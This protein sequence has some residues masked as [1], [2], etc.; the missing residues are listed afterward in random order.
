MHPTYFALGIKHFYPPSYS[1]E[2]NVFLKLHLKFS[3]P[4]THTAWF[5]S[6][7]ADC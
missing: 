4:I 6:N 7:M 2:K 5:I 3:T 1:L